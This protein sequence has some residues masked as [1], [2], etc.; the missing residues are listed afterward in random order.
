[1]KDSIKTAAEII[2]NGGIV[3]FPTE[4]VYGLGADA[5][6]TSAVQRI[7][8]IKE[9]PFYDPL[10]VHI[11]D[12]DQLEL[13]AKNI[14]ET[15]LKVAH[16]F[17]PGP[18]TIVT[19]KNSNVPDL[20]TAGLSTVAIRMP[21][22]EIARELIKQAGTPIAAPSANKFGRLSPTNSKHVLKQLKNIDYIIDGGN[23]EIGIE[24]TVISLTSDGYKILRPGVISEKE[25]ETLI[26][27]ADSKFFILQKG[28]QSPGLLKS[29][30]SPSV[31]L[32]I[33]GETEINPHNKKAG[34][35]TF[36]N[37]QNSAGFSE[38]EVLSANGDLKEA[39]SNLYGALHRLEEAGVDFIVAEPVPET[40]AG[41]AIMDRLRKAANKYTENLKKEQLAESANSEQHLT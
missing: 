7:F 35:L 22:N 6:N 29:H 9:R 15:L 31:P 1:M 18:L 32:F 26:H 17:W 38:V 5:F 41:I 3:A 4:T 23:A 39:A 37:Q 12:F 11:S 34:L 36:V 14:D 16:K 28:F 24:S 20:V 19:E 27:S 40:G 13:L 25:L 21:G 2:R 30:Y 10:I 8:E 33:L